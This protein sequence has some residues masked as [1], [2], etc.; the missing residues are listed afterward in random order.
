MTQQVTKDAVQVSWD[1]S[2]VAEANIL[3]CGPL[4]HS[5][6]DMTSGS[7]IALTGDPFITNDLSSSI[8]TLDV[9]TDDN[10]KAKLYTLVI[11][12]SYLPYSLP[13]WPCTQ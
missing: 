13:I 6:K 11:E 7:A 5:V 8:K 3:L 9:S 1:D 2:I 10:E 4:V 12:V